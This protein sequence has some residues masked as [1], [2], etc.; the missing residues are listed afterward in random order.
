MQVICKSLWASA[1]N[2]RS[3]QVCASHVEINENDVEA[4]HKPFDLYC[5]LIKVIALQSKSVQV[6]ESLCKSVQVCASLL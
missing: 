2:V 4:H 6:F 5:K 3:V 1:S